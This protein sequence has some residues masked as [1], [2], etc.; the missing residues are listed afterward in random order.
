MARKA[1][2]NQCPRRV[3]AAATCSRNPIESKSTL[4]VERKRNV[5]CE[6]DELSVSVTKESLDCLG[7]P[8][9]ATLERFGYLDRVQTLREG[10]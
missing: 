6:R 2:L 5:C 4:A 10:S 8:F 7:R 9:S 1:A 3:C